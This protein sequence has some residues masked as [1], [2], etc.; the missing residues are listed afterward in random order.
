MPSE[1]GGHRRSG[2]ALPA[3]LAVTGVVTL[4]FLVAMTALASLTAEAASARARVRFM[5]RALTAE[6][7]IAYLAATE[8][9]TAQGFAIG[10]A[11]AFDV[12]SGERDAA[13]PGGEVTLVRTDS[14]RYAA[15]VNG[16]L[17]LALRDQGGMIN[18]PRLFED[19]HGRLLARLNVDGRLI[20]P[21]WSRHQDYTDSDSATRIGGAEAA[22]YGE[23]SP[24]P[25]RRL[26]RPAEILSVL[27]ARDAVDARRWRAL[28]PELAA[29]HTSPF[30]NVN[31]ASSAALQVLF[32][33]EPRQAEAVIAA[34]ENAPL[35][36]TADFLAASGLTTG[37]DSETLYTMP[38]GRVMIAIEDGRSAWTY[39][40]RLTLTPSGL[41]QP[42]WIDQTE[43]TEAPR[44]AVADTSDAARFPYAPR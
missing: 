8:P 10:A 32:G 20:Q 11:R 27:G 22:D 29:D 33:L 25:N 42:L 43:M 40:A 16:L 2:F 41:E 7:A 28:R 36:S 4:V 1:P 44:R 24:P 34:R 39:R 15:E 21:L 19:Q 12:T 13:V 35:I 23:G 18:L 17:V 31:A 38:S 30:I 26:L 9:M 6:A 37:L 3:V 14:R 5:E